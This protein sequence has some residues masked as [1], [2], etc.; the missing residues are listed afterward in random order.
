MRRILGL[1][2]AL[3]IGLATLG[4]DVGESLQ[5][6]T[7][8]DGSAHAKRHRHHKRRHRKHHKHRHAPASEM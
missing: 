3:T 8:T 5:Q 2:L 6:G 1:G 4:I 7:I